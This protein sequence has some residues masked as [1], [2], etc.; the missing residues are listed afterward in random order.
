MKRGFQAAVHAA[1]AVGALCGALWCGSALAGSL[2]ES[3]T[4]PPTSLAQPE[5]E[6]GRQV[7]VNVGGFSRHFAR[8]RGYNE[9]NFGLGLEYRL[10]PDVSVMAG[11]YY[12]SIRRTTTYATANWQP[13]RLGDFKVGASIGVMDGYPAIARGGT[14]FVA[15]PMATY[16]GQRFGFN[17]GVI[18]S[19]KNVDG[20]IIL[21]LK[22]RAF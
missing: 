21:Q 14:F 4:P 6:S 1:G 12:N 10:N 18:P 3:P 16:E 8:H 19:T 20:A 7:W 2:G 15:V 9:S 22:V 17:V 11:S 13:Y 5:P